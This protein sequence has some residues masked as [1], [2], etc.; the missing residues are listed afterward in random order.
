MVGVPSARWGETPV[1]FVVLA[2]GQSCSADALLAW[3]NERVG[4]TQRLSAL[5]L[6]EVLPRSP[7]QIAEMP[8]GAPFVTSHPEWRFGR[9]P[10][11]PTYLLDQWIRRELP[12]DATYRAHGGLPDRSNVLVLPP[13][14]L[15]L[16]PLGQPIRR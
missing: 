16:I 13:D 8:K 14:Q 3:V 15:T 12:D 6:L 1:A 2:K 7:A 5:E 9:T 11:D 10:G 4:K